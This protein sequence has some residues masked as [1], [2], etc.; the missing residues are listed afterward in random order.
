[1][2]NI[3][4][5][6]DSNTWGFDPAN[7][8]RYPADKRWPG[9]LR[10]RL[11]EGYTVTENG[12]GGRSSVWEDPFL[13]GR[14]GKAGLIYALLSARPI[15]LV[16]LMLGTNDLKYTDAVGAAKGQQTLIRAMKGYQESLHFIPPVFSSKVPRILLIA[17]PLLG[18]TLGMRHTIEPYLTRRESEKLAEQYAKVAREERCWFLNAAAYAEASSIDGMHLEAVGHERLG[19]A[20]YEKVLAIFSENETS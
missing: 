14:S 1:M 11:G 12:I 17:P 16:I 13:P 10:D 18:E 7:T 5:Y 2:K 20:V 4:C 19:L 15:D 8:A 9:I 6:G 3:L